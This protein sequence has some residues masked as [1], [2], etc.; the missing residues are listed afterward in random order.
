M[1]RF[2]VTVHWRGLCWHLDGVATHSAYLIFGLIRYFGPEARV[3]CRAIA[4]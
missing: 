3:T 4:S 1:K 2:S